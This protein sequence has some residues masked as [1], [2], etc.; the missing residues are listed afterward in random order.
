MRLGLLDG[1]VGLGLDLLLERVSGRA[2]RSELAG[3]AVIGLPRPIL[4]R[5]PVRGLIVL[6]APGLLEVL[7]QGLFD[8]RL[9]GCGNAR[10]PTAAGSWAASGCTMLLHAPSA[11]DGYPSSSSPLSLGQPAR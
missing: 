11:A 5:R 3:G 9:L 8:L 4:G 7:F 6:G 10:D 1:V 2:P